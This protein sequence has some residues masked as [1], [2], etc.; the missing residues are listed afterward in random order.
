METKKPPDFGGRKHAGTVALTPAFRKQF[1]MQTAV[2][3]DAGC[4]VRFRM[5]PT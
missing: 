1:V 5:L 3:R 4:T 2:C